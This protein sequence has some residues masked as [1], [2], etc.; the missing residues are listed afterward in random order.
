MRITFDPAKRHATLA[1]RGLDFRD[2]AK[3]FAGR[4]A[5]APDDRRDYGEARFI[6]AGYLGDRLVVIV[7]TPRHGTRRV[8]SMRYAHAQEAKR[9]QRHMD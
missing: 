3:V 5:T 8:I 4:H 6:T 1:R 7:W 9:W 2:A